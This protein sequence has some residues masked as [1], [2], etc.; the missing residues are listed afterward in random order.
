MSNGSEQH[1]ACG[2]H[3]EAA[4]IQASL[5][6]ASPRLWCQ[7]SV[8]TAVPATHSSDGLDYTIPDSRQV[9]EKLKE[10]ASDERHGQASV[11]ESGARS[12]GGWPW[13]RAG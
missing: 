13:P 12:F 1:T 11:A 3:L 4:S 6:Q 7:M 5:L 9:K 8:E 10:R 2:E